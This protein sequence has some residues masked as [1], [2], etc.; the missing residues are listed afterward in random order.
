MLKHETGT[1]CQVLEMVAAVTL[2]KAITTVAAKPCV[3]QSVN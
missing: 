1:L 3:S 2:R